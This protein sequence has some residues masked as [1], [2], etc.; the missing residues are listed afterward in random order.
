MSKAFVNYTHSLMPTVYDHIWRG[1]NA[2]EECGVLALYPMVFDFWG[3]LSSFISCFT[4][5]TPTSSLEQRG[6]FK[7]N[8][9]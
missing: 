8:K 2:Q 1:V 9:R 3:E 4:L 5:W 6:Y 7:G